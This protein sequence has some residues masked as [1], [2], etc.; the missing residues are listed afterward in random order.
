M[1]NNEIVIGTEQGSLYFYNFD[2]NFMTKHFENIYNS[3]IKHI[4][5]LD[6]KKSSNKLKDVIA[7]LS[8]SIVSTFTTT[9][10]KSTSCEESNIEFDKSEKA[11]SECH[12]E[13]ES[14][15]KS[16]SSTSLPSISLPLRTHSSQKHSS[17][18]LYI[19]SCAKSLKIIAQQ[20]SAKS[21]S[22]QLHTDW[23]RGVSVSS[24][25][26]YIASC[27]VDRRVNVMDLKTRKILYELENHQGREIFCVKFSSDNRTLA[28]CSADSTIKLYDVVSRRLK[29]RCTN[30]RY[31]EVTS[32]AFS[33]N[34]KSLV[35]G[36][37]DGTLSLWNLN[38][39]KRFFIMKLFDDII[40][41]C[42]YSP[43]GCYLVAGCNDGSIKMVNI[44]T[45]ETKMYLQNT[46]GSFIN[47]VLFSPNGNQ[48]VSGS[49]DFSMKLY[50]LKDNKE[51]KHFTGQ[52]E[53]WVRTCAFSPDGKL[54]AGG[55]Y[56]KTIKVFS[57]CSNFDLI[58]FFKQAHTSWV[59]NITFFPDGK[60]L[61]SCGQDGCINI[62]EF[63]SI[64]ELFTLEK[65]KNK[66]LTS[67]VFGGADKEDIL[68]SWKDTKI[69]AFDKNTRI[70]IISKKIQI[71]RAPITQIASY[72]HGK[73]VLSCGK[74]RQIILTQ[75]ELGTSIYVH[76]NAFNCTIT[77]IG[78]LNNGVEYVAGGANG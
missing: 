60:S 57:T 14:E 38:K 13:C 30:S 76:E 19:I 18:D 21:F 48:L 41:T 4:Y 78:F 71:H 37:K 49:S 17:K 32:L 9:I 5:K 29:L 3:P 34:G 51:I 20:I 33:P 8:Q 70:P 74:D 47:S 50:D 67:M 43:C 59:M 65:S 40:F 31:Q 61:I 25:G 77:A 54:V 6:H 68:A 66:S 62:F 64:N 1:V 69:M 12:S 56:S 53:N 35:F 63:D 39:N 16:T 73:V 44:I 46:H 42:D 55:C 45:R 52:F 11:D 10:Q 58:Y 36:A 23:A 26:K 15:P 75:Y 2:K 27:G 7:N 24:D 22:K 28:S 72:T